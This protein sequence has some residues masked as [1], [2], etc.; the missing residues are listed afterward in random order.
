MATRASSTL[1][2]RTTPTRT[3]DLLTPLPDCRGS[4]ANATT[5]AMP[6]DGRSSGIGPRRRTPVAWRG[7]GY[8]SAR[9]A[10]IGDARRFSQVMTERTRTG[11]AVVVGALGPLALASVWIPFR[12]RLPNTDL[13]LILVLSV[14]AVGAF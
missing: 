11:L 7:G 4:G 8:S 2:S 9:P 1:I 3:G 14:V 13:A 10:G 6:P 12:L 5:S